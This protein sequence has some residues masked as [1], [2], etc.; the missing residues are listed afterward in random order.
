MHSSFK[1]VKCRLNTDDDDDNNNHHH[2]HGDG[3]ISKQLN[4][5][6]K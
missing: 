5:K 3:N 2:H 1:L 4:E 6:H